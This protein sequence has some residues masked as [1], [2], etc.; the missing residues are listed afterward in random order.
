MYPVPNNVCTDL[1]NRVILGRRTPYKERSP[2][3]VPQEEAL[4]DLGHP[5]ILVE[6]LTNNLFGEGQFCWDLCVWTFECI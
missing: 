4:E 2:Y 1:L 5:Y 3:T 6:L